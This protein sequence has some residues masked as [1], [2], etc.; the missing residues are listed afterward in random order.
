VSR[1]EGNGK[2]SLRRPKLSTTKG[3][4]TPRRRRMRPSLKFSGLLKPSVAMNVMA[5]RPV[6]TEVVRKF[7]GSTAIGIYPSATAVTGCVILGHEEYAGQR[8]HIYDISRA[9]LEVTVGRKCTA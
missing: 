6:Q 1:I 5:S 2:M 3:S 8:A 4:S 9:L 7:T